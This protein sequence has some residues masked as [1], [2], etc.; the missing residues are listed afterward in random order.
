[1]HLIGINIVDPFRYQK[2]NYI[3]YAFWNITHWTRSYW[4]IKDNKPG[5]INPGTE[6]SSERQNAFEK[7]NKRFGFKHEF[8]L[9]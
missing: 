1:M 2:G 7:Y 5:T 8:R 6:K 4:W 3:S 9:L